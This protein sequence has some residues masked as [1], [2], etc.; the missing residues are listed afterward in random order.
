MNKA[1]SPNKAVILHS[2]TGVG[3]V[4]NRCTYVI[5]LYPK[6]SNMKNVQLLFTGPPD[7]VP[8]ARHAGIL[9]LIPLVYYNGS[10]GCRH[11]GAAMLRVG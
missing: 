11:S 6:T 9:I 5:R 4:Y 2:I 7:L 3:V 1:T 10:H 8:A